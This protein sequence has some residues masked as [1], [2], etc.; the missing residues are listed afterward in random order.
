MSV[1][2]LCVQ[3]YVKRKAKASLCRKLLFSLFFW[4]SIYLKFETVHKFIE[5]KKKNE[6]I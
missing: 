5:S 6:L 2:N 3:K 1:K 4:S